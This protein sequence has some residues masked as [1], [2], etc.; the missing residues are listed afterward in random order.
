MSPSGCWSAAARLTSRRVDWIDPNHRSGRQ[1]ARGSSLHWRRRR[2]RHCGAA[3]GR[4]E[5]G[6]RVGGTGVE[7]R[8]LRDRPRRHRA[9]GRTGIACHGRRPVILCPRPRSLLRGRA[10]SS[11]DSE[12]IDESAAAD[13]PGRRR[14]GLGRHE[15]H[16]V[17]GRRRRGGRSS[18]PH[19][20]CRN[21]SRT[22]FGPSTRAGSTSSGAR[23]TTSRRTRSSSAAAKAA[24]GWPM[25]SMARASPTSAPTARR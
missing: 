18:R 17:G 16:E 2:E 3:A 15:C 8:A 11:R 19:R 4:F 12:L 22:S 23:S 7:G 10:G 21:R 1:P 13:G 25:S 5:H 20:V 9:P 24:C 6:S 14:P